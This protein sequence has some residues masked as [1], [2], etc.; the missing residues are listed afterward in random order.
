VDKRDIC[1]ASA[2]L[3][4]ADSETRRMHEQKKIVHGDT[5]YGYA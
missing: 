5:G 3:P 2:T 1:K 4:I